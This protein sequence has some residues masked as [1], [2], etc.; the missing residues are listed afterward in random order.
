MD[1]DEGQELE[2]QQVIETRTFHRVQAIRIG[3][4]RFIDPGQLAIFGQH[5]ED[6]AVSRLGF[7]YVLRSGYPLR[8]LDLARQ[9]EERGDDPTGPH[10]LPD[11]RQGLKVHDG[12]SSPTVY[13]PSRA[14]ASRAATSSGMSWSPARVMSRNLR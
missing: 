1:L 9:I 7:P 8:L 4:A 14:R 11:V 6:L 2:Q 13:P 10:Q 5:P 12:C 3:T